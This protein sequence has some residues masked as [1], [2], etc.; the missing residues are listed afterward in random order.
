MSY[1]KTTNLELNKIGDE[2]VF[3]PAVIT[4]N[5][6]IIDGAIKGVNDK[7]TEQIGSVNEKIEGQDF[8]TFTQKGEILPQDIKGLKTHSHKRIYNRVEVIN[9]SSDNAAIYAN[10]V[11]E[12]GSVF[13]STYY[14]KNLKIIKDLKAKDTEL[15]NLINEYKGL[16]DDYSRNLGDYANRHEVANN[17]LS[18]LLRGVVNE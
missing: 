3:D 11:N 2:N 4:E 9:E 12:S 14:F 16:V 1:E 13:G 15:L 8:S 10:Y 5:F 18:R 6:E 7:I 17:E